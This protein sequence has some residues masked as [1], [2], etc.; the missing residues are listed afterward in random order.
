VNL[1]GAFK[2][3]LDAI[4]GEAGRI[5]AAAQAGAGAFV[6]ISALG[7]MPGRPWPTRGPR[8]KARRR[9]RRVPRRDDPAP[10]GAVCDDDQFVT[11]FGRIIAVFP[12]VPVFGPD[13]RLQPLS[14]DD[15]AEAVGNALAHPEAHAGKVY[16]LAGPEVITMGDLNRRI[17]RAEARERTFIDLPDGVSGLI[18]AFGWLP[19]HR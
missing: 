9:A 14:V 1:V 7:P 16:E 8:P 11:M 5:A 15:A 12:V 6:H 2:G 13:A 17:A 4:Q 19:A 3:D 10:V 18:A